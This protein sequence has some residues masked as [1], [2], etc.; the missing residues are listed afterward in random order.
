MTSSR[1]STPAMAARQLAIAEAE[2]TRLRDEQAIA[3][4]AFEAAR[5][6]LHVVNAQVAEAREIR[7]RWELAVEKS[8]L[9]RIGRKEVA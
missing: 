7:S 3:V 9:P 6:R 1:S 5:T 4:R 2:F 8:R